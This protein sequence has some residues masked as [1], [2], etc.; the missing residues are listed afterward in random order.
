MTSGVVPLDR[1][2]AARERLRRERDEGIAEGIAQGRAE[3]AAYLAAAAQEIEARLRAAYDRDE[4]RLVNQGVLQ[5]RHGRWVGF[6]VGLSVG[7]MIAC[8]ASV[9]T[10]ALVRSAWYDN[11]GARALEQRGSW[12]PQPLTICEPGDHACQRRAQRPP[13]GQDGWARGREPESAR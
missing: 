13:S 8:G 9:G 3:F 11:A 4:A 1:Q 10:Y 5:A 6:A 12:E 7:V 2:E